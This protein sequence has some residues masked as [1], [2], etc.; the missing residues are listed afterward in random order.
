MKALGVLPPVTG[1]WRV[2]DLE[3]NLKP[4]NGECPPPSLCTKRGITVCLSC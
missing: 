2:G 1:L 4:H 3:I